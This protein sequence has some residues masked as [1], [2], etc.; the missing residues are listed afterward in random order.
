MPLTVLWILIHDPA[1]KRKQHT[2]ECKLLTHTPPVGDQSWWG[3]DV[4]PRT[5]P[6]RPKDPPWK[7]LQGAHVHWH[8]C[9]WNFCLFI[10]L[11]MHLCIYVSI[12]CCIYVS[13]HVLVY[14]YTCACTCMTCVHS[15]APPLPLSVFLSCSVSFSLSLS[16]S[17]PC[18]RVC[19][20][21]LLSF[22]FWLCFVRR[23]YLTRV[24]K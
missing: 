14:I 12:F 1:H 22:S 9:R 17:L 11:S 5:A 6:H 4:H 15:P 3:D 18:L 2:H 21:L 24:C 8:T 19:E 10:C 16:L 23:R 20:S 7:G 13:M